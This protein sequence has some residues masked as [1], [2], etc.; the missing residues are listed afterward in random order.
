MQ[1]IGKDFWLRFLAFRLCYGV[2]GVL[3]LGPKPF[4]LTCIGLRGLGFVGSVIRGPMV[5]VSGSRW[6]GLGCDGIGLE[7]STATTTKQV[8]Q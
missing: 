8:R 7:G 2:E 3:V 5:R 6:Q 1:Q 4:W